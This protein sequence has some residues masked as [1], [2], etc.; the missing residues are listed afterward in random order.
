MRLNNTLEHS[1]YVMQAE[2]NLKALIEYFC[3]FSRELGTFP[4]LSNRQFD[5]ALRNSPILW[6][7]CTS[8]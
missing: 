5:T 1:G 4:E 7:Y 2:Q 8:G 6:P 3:K